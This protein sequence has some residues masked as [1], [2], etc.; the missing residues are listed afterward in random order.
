VGKLSKKSSDELEHIQQEHKKVKIE[1]GREAVRLIGE[2]IDNVLKRQGIDVEGDIKVQ[3]AAQ[4]IN[5]LQ[6]ETVAEL[7]GLPQVAH[8]QG[9]FILKVS[10]FNVVPIAFVGDAFVDKEGLIVVQTHN[11]DLGGQITL[12]SGGRISNA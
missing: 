1:P 11:F 10:A 2:S 9:L 4:G 6:S 8:L 7:L 5:I 3:Q 12:L